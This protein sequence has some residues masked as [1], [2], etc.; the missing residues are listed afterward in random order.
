MKIKAVSSIRI[1]SCSIPTFMLMGIVGF[2]SGVGFSQF[3]AKWFALS[4]AVVWSL[5]GLSVITYGL[6]I[7]IRKLIWRNSDLVYYHHEIAL[8]VGSIIF[9]L[10]IGQ[11]VYAYLDI[12]ASGIGIFLFFGRI[13]CS[14]AG[15]CHGL[16]HKWGICYG[17]EHLSSGMP[18]SYLG[19]TLFPIQIAEAVFVLAILIGGTMVRLISGVEGSLFVSYI[20]WYGA[21]RFILEFYRGDF[22]R[23][24]YLGLS[25]AQWISIFFGYFLLAEE[26]RGSFP[27]NVYHLI[28]VMVLTTM[29]SYIIFR[30]FEKPQEFEFGDVRYWSELVDV[31]RNFQENILY[32]TDRGVNLSFGTVQKD[33]HSVFH[34]TL[35]GIGVGKS[36]RLLARK[37]STVIFYSISNETIPPLMSE[38]SPGVYHFTSRCCRKHH[39]NY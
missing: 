38:S 35:S 23:P 9:L 11:P 34:L 28:M 33:T 7:Y 13:G 36:G 22:E 8:F 4:G 20:L 18:R 14:M 24:Y 31:V 5:S 21:A 39:L 15:C 19:L 17:V 32:T 6:V 2:A 25:Q 12:V 30:Y 37:M 26:F 1:M 3:L 16:P 10:L 27:F 29:A